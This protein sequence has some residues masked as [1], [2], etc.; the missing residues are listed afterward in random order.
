MSPLYT[1][2]KSKIL[3]AVA[4]LALMASLPLSTRADEISLSNF[5][6]QNLLVD[7]GNGILTTTVAPTNV[8]L[9]FTGTTVGASMGDPA[10]FA[11]TLQNGTN[12]VNNG[13]N[14][15]LNTSTVG[16]NA[17]VV[18]FAT[19]RT[20][21]GFNSNQFQYSTDGGLTFI[22]FNTFTPAASFALQ[23]FNLSS[24]TALDNNPLAAFRIVFNGGDPASSAGNNR[25][26]NLLVAG[27]PSAPVTA[28]PEPTS[29]LLLG[30]GLASITVAGLRR[31]RSN[32]SC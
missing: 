15:T 24:I 26:D 25:I 29:M 17:I 28:V 8:V 3:I 14:L 22:T 7:R 18:S 20:T 32:R 12:G 23:S 10:G 4:A 5:N 31:R 1:L 19:Q 16:F 30:T 2:I 6:D 11:L 21:T 27:T 9:T 13:A